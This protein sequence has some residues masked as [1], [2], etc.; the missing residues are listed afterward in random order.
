[1]CAVGQRSSGRG[2]WGWL[3]LLLLLLLLLRGGC[4]RGR[5]ALHGQQM[6]FGRIKF[7]L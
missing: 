7:G 3:L 1:M 6:G 2:L 5:S 4:C